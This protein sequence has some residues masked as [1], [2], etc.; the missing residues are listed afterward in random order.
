MAKAG[1]EALSN[2]T[3]AQFHDALLDAEKAMKENVIAAINVF[4]G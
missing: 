4:K 3:Y 2:K 1:G